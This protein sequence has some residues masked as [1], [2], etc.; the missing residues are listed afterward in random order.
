MKSLIRF[1][2]SLVVGFVLE[3]QNENPEKVLKDF[4]DSF[5]KSYPKLLPIIPFFF[6]L[7][8]K[9]EFQDREGLTKAVVEAVGE[10]KDLDATTRGLITDITLTTV[11]AFGIVIPG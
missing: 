8:V 1:L 7:K 6:T 4:A 11:F 3:R 10:V 5:K 2:V 9:D